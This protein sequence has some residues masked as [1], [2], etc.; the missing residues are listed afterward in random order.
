MNLCYDQPVRSKGTTTARRGSGAVFTVDQLAR[1]GATTTRQVR[2]LQSHG[3]LPRP[4]LV[5]RTGYY[6]GEHLERL[7]AVQRL[8]TEGFS[9]AAIATLMRAWEGGATLAEVLGLPPTE[10]LP[11]SDDPD[12]FEGWAPHR[13]G[14]VLSVVPS[15]VLDH[16]P[17][18]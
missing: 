13:R 5:G 1:A 6:D 3:L 11:G 8:Q 9:L 17:A 12:V 15:T 18:S 16:P 7:R 2:A 14:R 10:H 4:R